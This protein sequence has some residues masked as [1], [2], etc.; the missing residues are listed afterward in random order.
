MGSR[1][2][3]TIC[4]N[5]MPIT[6]MGS[7]NDGTWSGNGVVA[8]T[9]DPTLVTSNHEILTYTYN[10]GICY[11]TDSMT[12]NIITIDSLT[13]G[14]DQTACVNIDEITLVGQYPIGGWWIGDAVTDSTLGTFEPAISGV[15]VHTVGYVYAE[16]ILGCLD[17]VYKTVEVIDI[18]SIT[19]NLSDSVCI[20]ELVDFTIVID[21]SAIVVWNFGDG[22]SAPGN[23]IQHSYSSAGLYTVTVAVTAN[24]CTNTDSS[25]IQVLGK[26]NADF[27]FVNTG[28]C[29][30]FILDYTNQTTG[31]FDNVF[32]DLGNGQTSTTVSPQ[33]INYAPSNGIDTTYNIMMVAENQ[34]GVDT[35]MDNITFTIGTQILFELP[36][37]ADVCATSFLF[38]DTISFNGG[39]P[40][41]VIWVFEGG[42]PASYFGEIP[43][44]VTFYEDTTHTITVTAYNACG[45]ATL[46]ESFTISYPKVVEAGNDT[47]ICFNNMPITL[48]GSPNAGTW[49]GNGVVANTFDPTLVT[50][51]HEIL[52]YTYNNGICYITD[53]MTVNIITIDS[54]TAGDDQTTCVNID[55][56]TLVGQ[57]PIGGWWIGNGIT[58]AN[59]GTFS[60]LVSD[61]GIHQVG[62]VYAEPILGC[63]DT[64]YKNVE[65]LP[66]PEIIF[67]LP[68]TVCINE[69]VNFDLAVD[70]FAIIDWDFGDGNSTFGN[71]E[72]HN[73]GVAGSYTITVSVTEQGCTSTDST[74]IYVIGRPIASFNYEDVGQCNTLLINFENTSTGH[75]DNSVWTLGNGTTS[76]DDSPQFVGYQQGSEFDTT[77]YI[78]L[79][80]SNQCGSSLTSKT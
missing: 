13:A 37:I 16:P 32:W 21:S 68:D 58:N 28:V 36:E 26:P 41:S 74:T 24:G 67:N 42:T 44:A 18:P 45:A 75:Y 38:N 40:D 57:Y 79:R 72:Q 51:N 46:S 3:T 78:S 11:I 50:S 29:N 35:L 23:N 65:V 10:N 25:F 14:D 77:Y 80:V 33:D 69:V 70:P 20:N 47:T 4:F 48:M 8:N 7:P 64:V 2:D 15:G 19:L 56:I 6:L 54:L 60:P 76:T 12:V 27:S 71:N 66:I 43:P 30:T 9:F 31:H 22:N 63:L 39:S 73:Y 61:T 17:T 5:N 59:L 1:N 55:E 34:C 49:S 53:S 52:T 62:Y